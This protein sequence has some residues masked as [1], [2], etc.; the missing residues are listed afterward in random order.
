M[1]YYNQIKEQLINNEI[2]KKVKD[3]SKNKNELETYFNVG[4]LLSEAG[5]HYGEGVIKEYSSKLTKELGKGYG[6]SNLKN[7]RK[8]YVMIKSQTLSDLLSWSHYVELLK[9][10]NI[11]KINYYIK[12]T[13][14]QNLSVRKLREKIK[15][16]EYER[17]PKET[18][19][20][21]IKSK[22]N[23]IEDFIKNPIIL[24]SKYDKDKINEKML[25]QIIL[26]DIPSFLKQL[27]DGYSFIDS[28]YPI[29]YKDKYNYIDILLFNYIY[30]CFVVVELKVTP[31]KKE[32]IGQ[33]EHYMN[34]VDS[35]LK[36]VFQNSTVGIIIT[37]ENDCFVIKYCSNKNLFSTTYNLV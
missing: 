7:M 8:F 32:H 33:I 35:N 34:Y 36:R 16:K 30:N 31:L 17:L 22:E 21:L 20:R 11:N 19:N 26:E 4:K 9:F 23:N 13:E 29:K 28:E 18:K 12:I 5:K 27:G 14:E 6:V 25:K 2:Y 37:K 15:L 1:N 3:Y 10:N 24:K